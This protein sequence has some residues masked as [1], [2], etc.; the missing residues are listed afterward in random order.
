MQY[1]K[2]NNIRDKI[3]FLRMC[4]QEEIERQKEREGGR[5]EREE[6]ERE[7]RGG[8]ERREIR[9]RRTSSRPFLR[10]LVME[11]FVAKKMERFCDSSMAKASTLPRFRIPSALHHMCTVL[12]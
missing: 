12:Q 2:V 7:R 9:I 6:R 3:G 1:Y 10:W 5:E 11:L 8:E 4:T